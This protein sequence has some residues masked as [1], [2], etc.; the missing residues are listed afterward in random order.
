MVAQN[1]NSDAEE[2]TELTN[3][4]D[5]CAISGRVPFCPS[6]SALSGKAWE[7]LEV[8]LLLGSSARKSPYLS[9]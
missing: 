6:S 9:S 2:G 8:D 7:R 5:E 4:P 3:L 1:F